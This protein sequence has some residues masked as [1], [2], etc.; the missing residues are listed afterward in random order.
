MQ[1]FDLLIDS[2]YRN[3]NVYHEPNKYTI[4]L[5]IT[6]KNVQSI[7]VHRVYIPQTQ[8]ILDNHNNNFVYKYENSEIKNIQFPI[9]KNIKN[10]QNILNICNTQFDPMYLHLQYKNN[11][12]HIYNNFSEDVEIYFSKETS[13]GKLLGF[14]YDIKINKNDFV[15]ADNDM[16]L[17]HDPYVNININKYENITHIH[18]YP[19]LYK[20]IFNKQNEPRQ[21]KQ[22][23]PPI[24]KLFK[25]DISFT[26]IYN[27]LYNFHGFDHTFNLRIK[28]L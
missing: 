8:Y 27:T 1:T 2:Q 9:M 24:G 21:L 22:F 20:H 6:Y 5:P 10:V 25:L 23:T 13:I 15:V 3:K 19:L 28:C 11:K 16:T 14:T 18:N 26:N 12:I 4:E 17:Q 7:E